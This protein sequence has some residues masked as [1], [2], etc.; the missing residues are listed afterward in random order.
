MNH[1][2]DFS[3]SRFLDR[4]VYIPLVVVSWD[5]SSV[6]VSL[7][8]GRGAIKVSIAEVPIVSWSVIWTFLSD[9]WF[10]AFEAKSF[11]VKV[12]SFFHSQ[13]VKVHSDGVDVHSVRVISG[14]RLVGFS[15]LISWS[16]GIS[17][18]IDLSESRDRW[19]RLSSHR[20]V[21]SFSKR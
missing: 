15:S 6:V 17:S 14:S 3:W 1:L 21:I 2:V 16:R 19:S 5:K 4:I 11:L 7:R 20:S 13:R 9:A 8:R 10:L 18:T 12:V